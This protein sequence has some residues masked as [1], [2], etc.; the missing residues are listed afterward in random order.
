MTTRTPLMLTFSEL[1][2]ILEALATYRA[3]GHAFDN[4]EVMDLY[5]RVREL[6]TALPFKP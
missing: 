4:K 1:A 2:L 5:R 6:L 3:S